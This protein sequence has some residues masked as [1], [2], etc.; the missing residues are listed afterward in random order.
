MLVQIE[1]VHLAFLRYTQDSQFVDGIHHR[2]RDGECSCG[3]DEAADRLR[4]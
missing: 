1:T 3:D 4:Q 2:V